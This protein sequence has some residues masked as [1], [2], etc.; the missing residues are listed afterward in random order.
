MTHLTS[1][2]KWCA[3][4]MTLLTTVSQYYGNVFNEGSQ[5]N[6]WAFFVWGSIHIAQAIFYSIWRG[7]GAF[8]RKI[9][10]TKHFTNIKGYKVCYG[11]FLIECTDFV[12]FRQFNLFGNTPRTIARL[13]LPWGRVNQ[14][15]KACIGKLYYT[16]STKF[17]ENEWVSGVIDTAGHKIGDFMVEYFGEFES[18]LYSKRL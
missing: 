8:L 7:P 11:S 13:L 5:I 4:S 17:V 1:G 18:T 14:S 15:K 2:D 16:I 12:L 3:V 9:S 10:K 6:L